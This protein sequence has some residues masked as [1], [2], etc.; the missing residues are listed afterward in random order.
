MKKLFKRTLLAIAG[1]LVIGAVLTP[2]IVP[3]QVDQAMNRAYGPRPFDSAGDAARALHASLRIA[4][5]H[6]DSL[7]WSRDLAERNAYGQVD[8]PRLLESN[9]ALQIFTVPSSVPRRRSQGGTPRDQLDLITVAAV[10]GAWPPSTWFRLDSRAYHL[11][12][13]LHDYAAESGG[14]FTVIQSASELQSYLDR[15]ER[16][17]NI[18]AGLLGIEGAHSLEGDLASVGRH[19]DAG[20]RVLGLVHFF[21][22]ELGGASYGVNKGGL[23]DFGRAVTKEMEERRMIVDLAHASPQLIDDVLAAATRP[24]VVSHSGIRGVCDRPR[25]LSDEHARAIAARGGLIGIGFWAGATCG[26]DAAAIARSVRYTASLVGVEHVAL[27]SDFDG[28]AMP[29]DVTGM[30]RITEALL[31]EGFSEQEIRLIMG[32][33]LLAFLLKNLPPE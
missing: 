5:L 4:D 10:A 3:R 1:L 17:G 16:D 26:E 22:N 28:D 19:F 11:A 25:N 12:E 6:A 24:M 15:R 18:T 20:Y 2:F 13:T 32:E 33:N 31:A 21:D 30:V 8:I 29:F 27:G 23:T 9:V 7:I 14:R